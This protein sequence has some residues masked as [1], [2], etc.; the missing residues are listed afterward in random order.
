MK[1]WN[2]WLDINEL[3][4]M[5]WLAQKCSE[6]FLFFCDFMWNR[7]LATVPCTFVRPHL[8]KEEKN[9][10]WTFLR[11]T[12]KCSDPKNAHFQKKCYKSTKSA[13]LIVVSF[14]WAPRHVQTAGSPRI[15]ET[16]TDTITLCLGSCYLGSPQP[17]SFAAAASKSSNLL[18]WAELDT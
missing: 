11:Y 18:G 2:E 7:A 1:D 10:T 16:Y 4:W 17:T 9:S 12:K 15:L 8:Q 3:T 5:K 14:C 13:H 6:P